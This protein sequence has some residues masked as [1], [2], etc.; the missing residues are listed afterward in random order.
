MARTLIGL[1][2][3]LASS[4][5]LMASTCPTVE[6]SRVY[7][8]M[9]QLATLAQFSEALDAG[10]TGASEQWRE[11][12]RRGDPNSVDW[13]CRLL[14]D[15]PSVEAVMAKAVQQSA[16]VQPQLLAAGGP[17]KGAGLCLGRSAFLALR[18]IHFALELTSIGLDGACSA[19]SC[20]PGGCSGTCSATPFV[21]AAMLPIEGLLD[22]SA[23]SCL[24]DHFSEMGDWAEDSLGARIKGGP[25]MTLTQIGV[26]ARVELL[27]TIE[28]AQA[29]VG[30]ASEFEDTQEVFADGLAEATTE[31][32]AIRSGL[33]AD[34]QR[35]SVFQDRLE[36]LQ[37]QRLLGDGE[38]SLP[39]LYRLPIA[40]GGQLEMV[41]EVVA[42][43]ING[44]RDAQLPLGQA[45]DFLR[46]GDGH[47]NAGRYAEAAANYQLSYREL[48]P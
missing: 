25:S 37:L 36:R 17:A 23:Y 42:D 19:T 20:I 26:A 12:L 35:R 18:L 8:Y 24:A 13:V 15:Y 6:M 47:Y 34:E 1:L 28:N 40:S 4:T 29:G 2:A 11:S 16:T 33:S 30:R 10:P 41:R 45:L 5:M 21:N 22:T 44:S 7:A 3:F 39:L 46:T 43:A 31:I 14:T 38:S 32:A 48:L 27:P 9:D